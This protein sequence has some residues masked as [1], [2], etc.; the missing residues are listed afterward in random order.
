VVLT[1]NLGSDAIAYDGERIT[2]IC[3]VDIVMGHRV[4]ITWRSVD[5]IGRG[6]RGDVLQL[7]SDAPVGTMDTDRRSTTVVTLTN[8]TQRGNGTVTI[9]TELQLMAS[10]MYANS[11]IGCMANG[12][13]IH[14][15]TFF[16][17]LLPGN[18]LILSCIFLVDS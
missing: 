9:V 8:R 16:T 6:R 15:V 4:V 17:S 12:T 14:W 10:A 18:A 1:H 3:T 11:R 5:Y 13:P 2:F 7:M